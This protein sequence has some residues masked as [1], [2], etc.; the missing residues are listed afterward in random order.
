MMR[1]RVV[2]V[3]DEQPVGSALERQLR[4]AGFDAVAFTDRDAALAAL[5]VQPTA[6]IIS[7]ERMPDC[8]GVELLEYCAQHFPAT[9]RILLTGYADAEVA[10]A[11]TN[12][13]QV[14]RLLWKP[15]SSDQLIEAIRA[16]TWNHE[17]IRAQEETELAPTT[18]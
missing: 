13:A 6:V 16:A 2:I 1:P 18:D 14:F 3:D 7:D 9:L 8:S 15:W 12:R 11:A 5:R 17:L 10:A 4:L